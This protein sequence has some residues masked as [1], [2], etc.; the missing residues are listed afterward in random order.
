MKS[1]C[2]L[3]KLL[4]NAEMRY[5]LTELKIVR[6]VWVVQKICHIIESV[7]KVTIIYTDYSI[8]VNIVCQSSLSTT[9]TE[10]INLCLIQT[11][12]YLQLF[13]LDIHYKSDKFNVISDALFKLTEQNYCQELNASTLNALYTTAVYNSESVTYSI[14]LVKLNREFQE[15]LITEY[16]EDIHWVRVKVMIEANVK[17]VKNASALLYKVIGEL[18]YYKDSECS[19]WL[20]ISLVRDI[21]KELFQQAHNGLRH[22]D[23]ARMHEHLTEELYFFNLFKK[24]HE[25]ICTCSQC[26]LC[27]TPKHKLYNML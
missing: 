23:Y 12:E 5:W 18:I 14:S 24:L 11:S 13:C 15:H 3:S 6:L 9:S 17:L 2:F 22:S 27:Q 25:F 1:I 20:S 8:T 26:Q 4:A 16:I 21:E 10:K 7:I 19:L